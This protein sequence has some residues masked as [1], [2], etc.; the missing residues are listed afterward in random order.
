M[1]EQEALSTLHRL[2]FSMNMALHHDP[3]PSVHRKLTEILAL[4]DTLCDGSF[5]PFQA[6]CILEATLR[7]ARDGYLPN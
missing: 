2:L 6:L 3:P 4:T 7:Q 1:S 5:T